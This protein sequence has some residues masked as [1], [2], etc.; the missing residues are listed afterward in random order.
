VRLDE[1]VRAAAATVAPEA[2]RRNVTLD[3]RVDEACVRGRAPD[4]ERLVRNL[5]DNALRHATAGGRILATAAP[6]A[7]GVELRVQDDGP[8]VPVEEREK[9]FEPFYR[10]ARA[11]AGAPPG[12]GLGLAIVREI[13]RAHGGDVT[14]APDDAARGGATFVV[15]LPA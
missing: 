12:A 5:L 6:R 15:S 7:G 9:I 8:G 10:G 11:R 2:A 13:A 3:F 4:L 14:L 1:V